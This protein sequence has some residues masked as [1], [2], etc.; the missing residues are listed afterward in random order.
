[1]W[2][3][4]DD[5]EMVVHGMGTVGIY[6]QPG[7]LKKLQK[8]Q[9]IPSL[10]HNL[11]SVGQLLTRGYLVVFNHD[12]CVVSDNQSQNQIITVQRTRNNMF[13]VDMTNIGR[14]NVAVMGQTLSELWNLRFGH[15]N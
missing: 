2:D 15:L 5:K 7:E 1:M 3:W 13:P 6:T 4:G 8:F 14:M 11:I 12:K 9:Y 10:A